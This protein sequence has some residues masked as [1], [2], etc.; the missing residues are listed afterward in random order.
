MQAETCVCL[1]RLL[2]TSLFHKLYRLIPWDYDL[3]ETV[4]FEVFLALCVMYS[5]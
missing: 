2:A 3:C 5:S 1:C 4:T